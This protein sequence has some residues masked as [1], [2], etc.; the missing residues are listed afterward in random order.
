VPERIARLLA[1]LAL[2]VAA[3]ASALEPGEPLPG[4]RIEELG[5]LQL[6]GEQI[7]FVPWQSG[8][9][10]GKV[11]VLQYLAARMSAKSLNEPFTDTLRDSGIPFERYHVTT[12][13]NLDDALIGTRGFV[14]GELEANKK[15]YW[16]SS[17]VAD[18]H[19]LGREAWH[20]RPKSSAIIILGPDG[21]VR[22][23]RDGPLS[24][25]DIAQAMQLVRCG[26]G[27]QLAL[28]EADAQYG[29]AP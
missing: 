1:A 21:R 19:G 2:G 3:G 17:I 25:A 13:V 22:F 24:T 29:C 6:A 10:A 8:A 5:E 26:A 12:I 4:L 9:L 16:R 28:L 14:L 27:G 11:Q 7:R 23:F 20:L 18:A 15:R